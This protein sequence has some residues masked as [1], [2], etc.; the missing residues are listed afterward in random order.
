[1]TYSIEYNIE[2]NWFITAIIGEQGYFDYLNPLKKSFHLLWN[3]AK[4]VLCVAHPQVKASPAL[5]KSFAALWNSFLNSEIFN[6]HH[7]F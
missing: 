2:I 7:F 1:M 6:L 3:A 4:S 5:W